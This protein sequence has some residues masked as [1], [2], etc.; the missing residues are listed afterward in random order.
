MPY[1]EEEEAFPYATIGTDDAKRMIE[2]GAHVIDVRQPD[3]WNRGHISDA[4]LVP[5]TGI[6]SL[7]KA[8]K[9]L[10]LP[11]HTLIIFVCATRQ[12]HATTSER[13]LVAGLNKTYTLARGMH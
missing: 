5:V 11:T 6:C 9:D 10:H 3:E 2:A 1:N 13:D 8:I 7:G 4:E 12:R